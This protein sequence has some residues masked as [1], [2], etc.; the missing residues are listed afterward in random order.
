MNCERPLPPFAASRSRSGGTGLGLAIVERAV[1]AHGGRMEA[2]GQN[3][4]GSS[5]IDARVAPLPAIE[6]WRQAFSGFQ[7]SLS[8]P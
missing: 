1:G 7:K 8:M 2:D 4:S 3:N 5:A 6:D